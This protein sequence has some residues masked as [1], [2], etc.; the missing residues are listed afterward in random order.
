MNRHLDGAHTSWHVHITI[1]LYHS[2]LSFAEKLFT[3]TAG[4]YLGKYHLTA[5]HVLIKNE[6]GN[7]GWAIRHKLL[8][9]LWSNCYYDHFRINSQNAHNFT[10]KLLQSTY[11]RR[12]GILWDDDMLKHIPGRNI[13][14]IIWKLSK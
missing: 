10:L 7:I 12:T 14:C 11:M 2:I 6:D 1:F 9:L 5:S 4:H 8:S 3:A 13:S